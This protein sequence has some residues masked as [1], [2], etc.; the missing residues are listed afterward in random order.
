M[1]LVTFTNVKREFSGQEVLRGV[2]FEIN[3]GQKLGLIGINGCGKTTLLRI[4]CGQ[5][6]AQE[7]AVNFASDLRVGYVPQHVEFERDETVR[8]YLE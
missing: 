3:A 6:V 7:G 4:L 8:D 5:E 1:A 2:S